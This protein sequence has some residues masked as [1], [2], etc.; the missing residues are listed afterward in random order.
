[1]DPLEVAV[2]KDLGSLP[3]KNKELVYMDGKIHMTTFLCV[4]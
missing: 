4:H 2:P 1:M 3:P